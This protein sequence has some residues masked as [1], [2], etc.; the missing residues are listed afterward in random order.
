MSERSSVFC[1]HRKWRRWMEIS[2]RTFCVEM[3]W[4]RERRARRQMCR[5]WWTLDTM[6]AS[7]YTH[8]KKVCMVAHR[9]HIRHLR[10]CRADGTKNRVTYGVAYDLNCVFP[11]Q[12]CCMMYLT[13][14]TNCVA[15][16]VP[17]PNRRNVKHEEIA[18]KSIGAVPFTV[19]ARCAGWSLLPNHVRM[20]LCGCGPTICYVVHKHSKTRPIC[21]WCRS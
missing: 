10:W 2:T 1:M 12:T 15:T 6:T 7:K 21:W 9:R 14:C 11:M 4:W 17:M 20:S 19:V 8:R 3:V 18:T 5:F 16:T 13:L